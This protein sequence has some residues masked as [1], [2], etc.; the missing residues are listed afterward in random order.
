VAATPLYADFE[1]QKREGT[2]GFDTKSRRA[3]LGEAHFFHGS[4]NPGFKK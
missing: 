1:Q 2:K 4:T 3:E